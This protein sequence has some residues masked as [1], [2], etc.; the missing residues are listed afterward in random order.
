MLTHVDSC[1]TLTCAPSQK[2]DFASVAHPIRK[3]VNKARKAPSL[4]L[5]TVSRLPLAA[6]AQ[7]FGQQS[8]QR[9]LSRFPQLADW[10]ERRLTPAMT[11]AKKVIRV[12]ESSD[13]AEPITATTLG[14]LL[15]QLQAARS[16]QSKVQLLAALRDFPESTARAAVVAA[17]RDTSVEVSSAAISTLGAYDD[18]ASRASLREVLDDP[19]AFFHPLSRTA[20]L[21]AL[22]S[23]RSEG[24]GARVRAALR[25]P[26][27]EVSLAA[28]DVLAARAT[29]EDVQALLEVARD[30]GG[31]FLPAVRVHA[32][33]GLERA[34]AVTLELSRAQLVVEE[35]SEVRAYLE[36][37]LESFL[38]LDTRGESGRRPSHDL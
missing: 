13:A 18:D 19:Q 37:F 10:I 36:S 2:A 30:S 27:A 7:R 12:G 35:A 11:L 38:D 29:A 14:D 8:V 25:D 15:A 20:A 31:Y 17:L 32:W 28:I 26:A 16:W 22:A 34:N 5:A 24:E 3:L 6:R 33:K 4:A 23:S 21:L 9:V 1:A